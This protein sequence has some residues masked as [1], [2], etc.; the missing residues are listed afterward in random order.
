MAKNKTGNEDGKFRP[1][2]CL[3][4]GLVFAIYENCLKDFVMDPIYYFM[5][6]INYLEF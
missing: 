2:I 6:R 5:D 1:I 3:L 4:G